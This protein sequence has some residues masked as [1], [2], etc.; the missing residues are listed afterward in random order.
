M[1][2]QY[3]NYLSFIDIMS[4]AVEV[5]T[6]MLSSKTT[7]DCLE[8]IKTFKLLYLYGV[9]DVE[10]GLR[11]ML[12]LVFHKEENILTETLNTYE[13]LYFDAKMSATTKTQNLLDLMDGATLTDL[14]CTEELL[15]KLMAKNIIEK[16]VIRC[17]IKIYMLKENDE[18]MDVG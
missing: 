13:Q 16:D 4:K 12:T 11:K 8:A 7:Q 6:E 18:T 2:Q 9:K 17:L 1:L 3:E 10:L 14:T 5:L 15:K